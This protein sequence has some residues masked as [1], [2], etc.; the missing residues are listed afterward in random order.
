MSASREHYDRHLAAIYSWMAGGMEARLEANRQFF[1][2]CGVKTLAPGMAADLG[3]GSG[4]QSIP[5]AESG[6]DVLA[7]DECEPMLAELR[8]H[9]GA[10]PIRAVRGNLL[11][12][13]EHLGAPAKLVI[14]MGDTLTH[15]ESPGAAQELLARAQASLSPGGWLILTFRD[16]V[17]SELTGASRFIPVRNDETRIAT[18][19][20]EYRPESVQVTDLLYE[21]KDGRWDLR[22]SSYPKLRL[23]REQVVAWLERLDMEI[24][25]NDATPDRMACLIAR[26]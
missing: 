1:E 10:L 9:A 6:F 2:A 3:C 11:D 22:V 14:C 17:N 26:N 5:L 4:F 12:F 20:L 13:G 21:R 18:V 23:A 24:I 25:R 7:V 15:L 19:F 8:E 16:Y